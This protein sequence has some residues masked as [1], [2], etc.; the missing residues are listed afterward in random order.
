MISR[1]LSLPISGRS[2]TLSL[3]NLTINSSILKPNKNHI[4]GINNISSEGQGKFSPQRKP[5]SVPNTM[6]KSPRSWKGPG[7]VAEGRAVILCSQVP[8]SRWFCIGNVDCSDR[9]NAACSRYTSTSTAL[10]LKTIHPSVSSLF[11]ERFTVISPRMTIDWLYTTV[12]NLEV[13]AD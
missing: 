1:G 2:L 10:P 3:H 8:S 5:H 13:T 9:H 4:A 11:E 12:V 6:L 7:S